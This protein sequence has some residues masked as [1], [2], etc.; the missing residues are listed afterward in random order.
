MTDLRQEIAALVPRLRRFAWGLSGSRDD[1]DDLVQAACL[2]AL[3][4]L[5]QF[6]PGTRLDSWMYR[7]VRTVFIDRGRAS[8]RR[9]PVADPEAVLAVSDEGIAARL[10]QDRLTLARVREAVDELPE[11]QRAVVLLVCVEGCSYREAADI[12]GVPVGT[13]MSR[14]ARGRSRLQARL[15]EV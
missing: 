1:G 14:L 13:V 7:I 15:G 10:P 5:D 4:R 3:E 8:R 6:A 2:R 9:G 12:L 11:G